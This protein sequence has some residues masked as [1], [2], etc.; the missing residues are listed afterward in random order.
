MEY[1]VEVQNLSKHFG[2]EPVLH[3]IKACLETGHIHGIVGRNGSGKTVLMKC[4]L[5]FLRPNE[6]SV[7]VFGKQIGKD[8]DFAPETGMIIE[9]PG[10]LPDESGKNNLQWLLSL[11]GH[12]TRRHRAKT[13]AAAMRLVGLDP[14]NRK[15]V[16]RY[17]L[18]M[19][20]RLGVAQAILEAPRLLVLD[21]PMNSL[22]NQG[23]LEMRQL[24]LSLRDK[25]TTIL[26]A[27]HNPLDITTLCD[28]VYEM[29]G[30]RLTK[31]VNPSQS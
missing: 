24:F 6:G 2:R 17:S 15:A 16:G 19:R 23:V 11:S 12:T 4:I 22:D 20:Q 29:D 7:S 25:G 18:G 14:T 31:Q 26:L 5:G 9:T 21:E 13:V 10:F 30:G 28:T 27:S 1:A 8:C 3:H